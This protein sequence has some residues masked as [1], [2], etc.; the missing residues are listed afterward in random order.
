MS[1]A[2]ALQALHPQVHARVQAAIREWHAGADG[3]SFVA[4]NIEGE[5]ALSIADF[6]SLLDTFG[7]HLDAGS[8]PP[9]AWLDACKDHH[10][11]GAVMARDSRPHVLGRALAVDH[12]AKLVS[13]AS[14]LTPG[15]A[16]ATLVRH[17][18]QARPPS[19]VER[20]LRQAQLGG[21]IMW[22][23]FN[24]SA[25]AS[26]PFDALAHV[27]E[28]V[29]T[30]LGLGHMG[31][32]ELL[33]LL[34]YRSNAPGADPPLHRPTIAEAG[35]FPFYRPHTDPACPHGYTQ[36]LAPNPTALAPQPEVVHP[37]IIGIGLLLPYHVTAP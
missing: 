28:Q 21:R 35:D 12:F 11:R 13:N 17:A 18:G 24:A 37:S 36:P 15:D 32:A 33:V 9:A 20:A 10:F 5:T 27:T 3:W 4:S 29:R 34:A 7:R 30:A 22:A 19:Y 1:F 2:A 6:T 26:N 16:R 14:G 23:T 31:A 8:A 25:P